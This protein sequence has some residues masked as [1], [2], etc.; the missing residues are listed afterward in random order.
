M[1]K[2]EL[3][4]L[5]TGVKSSKK[6]YYTEL[7]KTVDQLKKKNMQLEIMNDIT[8][9]MNMEIDIQ[10]ILRNVIEK[11]KQLIT[12]DDSHFVILYEEEP[13]LLH[14]CPNGHCELEMDPKNLLHPFQEFSS[15]LKEKQPIQVEVNQ[16][17]D[18]P[19]KDRLLSLEIESLLLVPL[20][21]K[22]KK[23]GIWTFGRKKKKTW[24]E[25]ELEFLEQLSNQL[26][27][28]LENAQLYK[29]VLHSKQEWEDTF[30]AVEDM[31]IVFDHKGT[32]YQSNDSARGFSNLVPLIEK[33]QNLIHDTFSFNKPGFQEILLQHD[34]ILEMHAYPIQNKEHQVYGVI[35][36]Y[37]NVTERRQMEV[38]LLHAGKLGAIGEM[39]AGI[40]HELNSPLT[41]ILGNSQ[42]LL[43]KISQD[44]PDYMLLDDI[45]ICGD[46]CRQIVKS[47]LT[48]SRQDEYR[49]HYY[50]I[51]EAIHQV[52]NL[53]KYQLGKKQISLHLS[54]Q[55]D[56]PFIKGS[57]PQIEQIIINLLLNAKDA[58]DESAQTEKSISITTYSENKFMVV[59]VTDNGT[60]IEQERL[61]FIF[62]PFHT[63][64]D[65]EKGTGLGL[66]VSL[67]IAED[68]GGKIDV[69]S[70]PGHG[71]TFFLRLPLLTEEERR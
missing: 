43:R 61:P 36:Y 70:T 15:A 69:L 26:A 9:N 45:K 64:K 39:A 25:A 62:H 10:E 18:F 55:E 30:K 41:A 50:S 8:K 65:R 29:E 19:E 53:L 12:F 5:M 35:A 6:T 49:F 11:L 28:T 21:G 40:A 2:H 31:I 23:I 7:K 59:Q 46:R 34:T 22:S 13:T 47:L 24:H 60:G 66:S 67:G 42:I 63:T 16:L 20:Y 57:Q 14:I 32:V 52:L 51:N 44:N 33:S 54:L 71:S 27:L 17:S 48:F 1:N 58:L 68:H 38:Q 37:K 3:I 4:D 56:L